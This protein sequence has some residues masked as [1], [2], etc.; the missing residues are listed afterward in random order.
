MAHMVPVIL[1]RGDGNEALYVD[2]QCVA[3]GHSIRLVTALRALDGVL[4]AF[5]T[6]TV[7]DAWLADTAGGEFPARWIDIPMTAFVEFSLPEP[8]E[9]CGSFHEEG[10]C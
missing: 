1:A 6:A 2:G 5:G 3:Q 4:Y 10:S 9:D 7:N 8:C